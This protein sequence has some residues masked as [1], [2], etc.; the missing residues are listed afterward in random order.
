MATW[1]L[2]T[3][4][5]LADLATIEEEILSNT[6]IGTNLYTAEAVNISDATNPIAT[7]VASIDVSNGKGITEIVGVVN[8]AITIADGY[9]LTV[10]LYDSADDITFAEINT[11]SQVYYNAASGADTEIAVDT[12]IFRW[13]V[14]TT[15][16]DHLK[17]VITS[18]TN[19][20]G[21]LDIYSISKLTS[22]IALA[23]QFMGED[24]E[25]MLINAG[26]DVG[27]NYADDEILLDRIA[28]KSIFNYCSHYLTLALIFE[29]MMES[30]SDTDVYKLKSDR[31]LKRY[32][33]RMTT[34]FSLKNMDYNFDDTVDDYKED[35]PPTLRIRR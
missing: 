21:K 27:I 24:L 9:S 8:T 31:F 23:K 11:G 17:A 6:S 35:S 25:R 20:S 3:F 10:K 26:L 2:T 30:G 33:E 34:A 13:V 15:C 4:T 12:E 32:H 19:N 1:A 16:E 28:N 18:S 5:T 14:P 29:D 7:N 22:K